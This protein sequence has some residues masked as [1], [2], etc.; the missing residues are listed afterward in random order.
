MTEENDVIWISSFWRRI[1]A[2]FVDTVIIGIIGFGLGLVLEKQFVELGGW[3]RFIGFFIALAYFGVLNSKL[4]GGQTFG[5]KILKLK[6]VNSDNQPIDV[7]RSFA[8]YSV[9][10]IPFFLNGAHFTNEALSSFWLYPLSL[11]VFGGGISIVYLYIF[12]RVTRQSLHDLVVGTFVVNANTEKQEIGAIWRPHLLVMGVLFVIAA[13]V[14][15]YTTNLAQSEPFRELLSAQTALINNSSVSYAT[16]SYGQ[17]SFSSSNE[18]TKTTTYVSAQVFLKQNSVSDV[19]LA[20]Q[21]AEILTSN[22][23]ESLQKDVV[24]INL[25]YGYDIGITSLWRNHAHRFNPKDLGGHE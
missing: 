22:Y 3:G 4:Y 23:P 15:M 9:L 7:L 17:S 18:G 2:F 10:G 13:I 5:K 12:N 14:P 24:Q 21:L 1:S 11:V 20:R 16:V 25:T 6:V 8:R 19:K